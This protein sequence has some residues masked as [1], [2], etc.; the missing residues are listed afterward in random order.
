MYLQPYF[1]PHILEE[2]IHEMVRVNQVNLSWTV[3]RK[4]QKKH[5][6]HQGLPSDL[7]G[8]FRWPFQGLS[9][10]HL[11]DQKVTWKKLADGG[12]IHGNSAWYNP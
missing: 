2:F 5:I 4:K 7:F 12:E 6:P 10:L 1:G 8:C 11:G 9:D 3:L